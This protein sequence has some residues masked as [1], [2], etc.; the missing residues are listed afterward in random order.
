MSGLEVHRKGLAEHLR[1][2]DAPA[3]GLLAALLPN[4]SEHGRRRGV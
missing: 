4:V 2:E 1:L 3:I